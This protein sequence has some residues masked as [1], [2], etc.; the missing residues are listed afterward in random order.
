MEELN[1]KPTLYRAVVL[2]RPDAATLN[3][4]PPHVLVTPYRKIT[5]IAIS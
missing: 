3:T 1:G 2:N 5:F 4:V